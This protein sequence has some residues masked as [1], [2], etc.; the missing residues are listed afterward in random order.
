MSLE[1]VALELL[2]WL[3]SYVEVLSPDTSECDLIC[4]RVIAEPIS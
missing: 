3:A 1:E 2:L 4:Y